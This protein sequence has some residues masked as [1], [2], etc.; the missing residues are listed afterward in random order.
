MTAKKAAE[1]HLMID[2]YGAFKP[3]GMRRTFPNV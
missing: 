2:F 1:R 3:D